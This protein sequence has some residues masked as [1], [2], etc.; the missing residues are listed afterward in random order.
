MR[1]KVQH[2]QNWAESA[3]EGRS[4]HCKKGEIV[5]EK[6]G[7]VSGKREENEKSDEESDRNRPKSEILVAEGKGKSKREH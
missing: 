5:R 3:N 6:G 2:C 4:Q 7:K 1:G